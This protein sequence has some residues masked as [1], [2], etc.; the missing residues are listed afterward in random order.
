MFGSCPH[1]SND[2]SSVGTSAAY[3]TAESIIHQFEQVNENFDIT[4]N[5]ALCHVFT[6]GK[7]ANDSFTFKEM[8][9]QD[10]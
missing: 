3:T 1:C 9:K 6:V 5:D 10:Y 2:L 8:I 7:E 4:Y